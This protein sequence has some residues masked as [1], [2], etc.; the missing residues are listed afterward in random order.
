MATY[1]ISDLH[2]YYKE[3]LEILDY[4]QF[5]DDDILYILG[6]VF[7]KGPQV[8]ELCRYIETHNNIIL[9]K[10]NHELMAEQA[11][12]GDYADWYLWFHRNG[13]CQTYRS[14]YK[15]HE[16]FK[17]THLLGY[18]EDSTKEKIRDF[19]RQLPLYKEIEVNKQKYLLVHAGINPKI[20][21]KDQ[22]EEDLLWIRNEFWQ[23]QVNIED[24]IVVF[25][26]TPASCLHNSFNDFSVWFD[27][28]HKDKIGIDGGIFIPVGQVNCLR[29]DDMQVFT[30]DV[31][32]HIKSQYQLQ[33]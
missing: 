31:K 10:G 20:P 2:G 30:I 11:I 14:F 5:S 3:F 19:V 33:I 15:N 23:S 22:S 17:G 32:N 29:L 27:T 25:G 6:D 13:G 7:D 28:K 8:Y 1:C 4:I 16:Y 9:L 26:H 18:P 24:I 12:S 21:L